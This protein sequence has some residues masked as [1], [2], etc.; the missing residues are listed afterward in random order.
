MMVYVECGCYEW[1]RVIFNI[2]MRDGLFLSV[3]FINILLYVLCVDGRFE[4]LYVVVEEL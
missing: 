1:V 2:M 4:E 3:E